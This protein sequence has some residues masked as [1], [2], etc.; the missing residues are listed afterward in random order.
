MLWLSQLVLG[1]VPSA[2]AGPRAKANVAR[3]LELDNAL[4]EAHA[5]LANI[6][7]SVDW[8]WAAAERHTSGPSS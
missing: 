7:F 1:A 6:T 5:T 8:D 2:E 4:A 3:A